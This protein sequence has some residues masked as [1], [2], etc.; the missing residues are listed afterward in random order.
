MI[1]STFHINTDMLHLSLRCGTDRKFYVSS[2]PG[3]V[4]ITYPDGTAFHTTEMQLFLYK[5][6]VEQLR[7]QA[8]YYLPDRLK[9][10]AARHGFEFNSVKINSARTRWGSCSSRRNINLSLFLMTL[11]SHLT[12]YVLLHELCHTREMNH[13]PRFWALMDIVTANNARSLRAELRSFRS[14]FA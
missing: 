3:T 14:P 4:Y 8:H 2:K 6:I 9:A 11:P 1:D 12:D 7:K 10:L 13:G 5:A